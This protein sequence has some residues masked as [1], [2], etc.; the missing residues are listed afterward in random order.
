MLF[1]AQANQHT[2]QANLCCSRLPCYG[3]PLG[4]CLPHTCGVEG[5][6]CT[7]ACADSNGNASPKHTHHCLWNCPLCK[8]KN[9]ATIDKHSNQ[10]RREGE[11]KRARR[12]GKGDRREG[13]RDGREGK[14]EEGREGMQRREEASDENEWY[15]WPVAYLL[16]IVTQ[17][18]VKERQQSLTNGSSVLLRYGGKSNE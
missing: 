13:K 1:Q 8:A 3:P 11:R 5:S 6:W 4:P 12:E 10:E 14:R 15:N 7:P 18:W 2:W 16:S 9:R 17:S